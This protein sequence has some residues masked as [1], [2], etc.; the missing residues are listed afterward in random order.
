[1]SGT[2][3]LSLGQIRE[4]FGWT[5][6]DLADELK[7]SVAT[8]SRWERKKTKQPAIAGV[9]R[10]VNRRLSYVLAMTDPHLL[11]SFDEEQ[12]FAGLLHGTDFMAVKASHGALS[13][14][15][16]LRAVIGFSVVPLLRGQ[17]KRFFQEIQPEMQQAVRAGN[18]SLS[19]WSPV[20]RD[21]T[22]LG[23]IQTGMD[24]HLNFLSCGLI[25][26]TG[27]VL[28]DEECAAR[29]D[30]KAVFEYS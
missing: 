9:S 15:V 22:P 27:R 6:V 2:S 17:T 10:H 4:T 19:W 30:P 7:V 26:L 12:G 25:H 16:L 5:Q 3:D 21:Q 1:M 13:K 14:N 24:L 11:G 29:P 23:L 18:A 20:S 8:L 28:S